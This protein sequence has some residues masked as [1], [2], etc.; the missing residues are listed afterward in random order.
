M[1]C[2]LCSNRQAYK[3]EA[4]RV[5]KAVKVV[6]KATAAAVSPEVTLVGEVA[7]PVATTVGN[8]QTLHGSN[9]CNYN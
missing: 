4:D 6:R 5:E 8:W 2:T 1:Q 3:A 7:L 9:P